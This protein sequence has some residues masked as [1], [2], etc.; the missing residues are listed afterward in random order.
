MFERNYYL[1][2]ISTSAYEDYTK[3]NYD[4]LAQNLIDD[5][6]LT[7]KDFILDFGCATG[8]LLHSL[9]KKGIWNAIGTDLSFWAVRY[10][11]VMYGHDKRKLQHYNRQLLQN[12]HDYVFLFDVLEHINTEE[13]MEIFELINTENIIVRVPVVIKEGED[14]VLDVHRQDQTHI[15]RHPKDWWES[16]FEVYDYVLKQTFDNIAIWDS[17]GVLSRA[18]KK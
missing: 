5:L 7:E 12:K 4:D 17:E 11:R 2:D 13:L 3:K 16:L 18:Y 8:A 15:Q 10:G 6:K 14:Y 9:E 1:K